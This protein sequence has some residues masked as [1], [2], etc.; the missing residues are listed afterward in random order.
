MRSYELNMDTYCTDGNSEIF[1]T[2]VFTSYL[3]N[4]WAF[5]IRHI[6]WSDELNC[7]WF[8]V[9]SYCCWKTGNKPTQ[10]Y[11]FSH[12]VSAPPFSLLGFDSSGICLKLSVNLVSAEAGEAPAFHRPPIRH[13]FTSSQI[14]CLWECEEEEE[15]AYSTKIIFQS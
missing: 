9:E 3:F 2:L 10:K 6:S 1:L 7:C 12:L 13:L 4:V 15:A 14:W 5:N 8:P 11:G